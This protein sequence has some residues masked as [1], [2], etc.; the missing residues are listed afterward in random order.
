MGCVPNLAAITKECLGG[1]APGLSTTIYVIETDGVDAI[2]AP[3]AH[4]ISTLTMGN[5]GLDVFF[6][7]AISKGDQS[8]NTEIEGE[9]E[10]VAYASTVQIFI[11]KSSSAKANIL[12]DTPGAEFIVI[13][14]DKQGN[15]RILGSLSEGASIV[16]G[17]SLT[18]KNGFLVTITWTSNNLPY[19]FTGAVP[20]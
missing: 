4:E 7:W 14:P 16:A 5:G 19:Y 13:V 17:E 2:G 1:N 6:P 8:Y 9:N 18:D 20:V 11:P 15:L 12:N 10:N 3:V